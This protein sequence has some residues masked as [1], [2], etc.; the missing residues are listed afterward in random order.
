MFVLNQLLPRQRITAH[1]ALQNPYC[2]ALTAKI[3]DLPDSKILS[4]NNYSF[5]FKFFKTLVELCNSL[6][7]QID[8]LSNYLIVIA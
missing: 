4:I 2:A 8:Q 1:E 5:S 3:G 6:S 7:F